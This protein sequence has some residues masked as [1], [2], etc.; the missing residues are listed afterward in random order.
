MKECT[1]LL[2]IRGDE[3]L[4]AMK[5]RGFGAGRWN[6]VGGKIEP[7]ETIEQAAIRECQ[8]EIGVTPVQYWPVAI[9][10]FTEMHEAQLANLRVYAYVCDKWEGEPAES[11]EMR[12]R[13]FKTTAIPYENM[14]PDDPFW[15][16]RVLTG[17]KLRTKFVL[18]AQDALVS[19]AEQV[20]DM[21]TLTEIL[22]DRN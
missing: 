2:L 19:H 12:P 20:V 18:D 7:G 4:L 13:W 9:H 16:P 14:W 1:L 21:H 17:E 6:G 11:E 3:I 5:K 15:L 22:H 8:E 10:D